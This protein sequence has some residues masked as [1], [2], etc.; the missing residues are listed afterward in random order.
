VAT[1][2]VPNASSADYTGTAPTNKRVNEIHTLGSQLVRSVVPEHSPFFE[3]SLVVR[4]TDTNAVLNPGTDYKC[5]DL[6]SLASA[7]T[8]GLLVFRTILILNS[9]VSSVAI[10]YQ[11]LGGRWSKN[12]DTAQALLDNLNRDNRPPHWE[13]MLNRPV[14]YTPTAHMT[15]AQNLVGL[16]YLVEAINEVKTAIL[17]GDAVGHQAIYAYLD[18]QLTILKTTVQSY[19]DDSAVLAL[20]AAQ[21]AAL[22]LIGLKNKADEQLA[23]VNALQLELQGATELANRLYTAQTTD[24]SRALAL[25]QN[26]P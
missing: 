4:R 9:Q 15:S 7:M 22:T 17:M 20:T 6:L 12:F 11:E 10:D 19:Q 5:V 14:D 21:N 23:I 8:G 2:P 25:I 1:S 13:N 26:N 18:A 3:Q 24:E 16:E